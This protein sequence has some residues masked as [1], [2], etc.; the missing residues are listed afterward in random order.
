MIFGRRTQTSTLI[1]CAIVINNIRVKQFITMSIEIKVKPKMSHQQ[2]KQHDEIVNDHKAHN[3]KN[4]QRP[5]VL[6]SWNN[7]E[8][9]VKV[10]ASQASRRI[11]PSS[12]EEQLNGET[13]QENA[14]SQKSSWN[15]VNYF[16]QKI[17]KVEKQVLQPMTGFVEPGTV[18]AIMGPR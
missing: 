10:A 5:S 9:K 6:L 1:S 11:A 14:S 17:A 7:L 3:Q 13:Q 8:F 16:K 2:S 15:P 12:S 18:L 4:H